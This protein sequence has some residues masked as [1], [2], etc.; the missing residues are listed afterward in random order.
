MILFGLSAQFDLNEAR[1]VRALEEISNDGSIE[2]SQVLKV[3]AIET[4]SSISV[5][6]NPVV[7]GTMGLQMN[8][9]PGG[10]YTVRVLN[11]FGQVIFSKLINHG[12]GSATETI[13]VGE[14]ISKGV[15]RLEVIQPDNNI[16]N[17]KLVYFIL[18]ISNCVAN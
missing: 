5:Y 16:S 11:N 2:Y 13:Q 4:G 12:A 15:Y 17:I 9:M 7:S 1:S 18:S 8:N 14:N 10:N 3:S 6:P